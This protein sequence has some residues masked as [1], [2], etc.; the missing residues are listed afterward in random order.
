VGVITIDRR[1]RCNALDVMTARDLHQATLTMARD[2]AVR[3]VVLRGTGG[4]FCS[5]ADQK[6]IIG[7][8]Q[9][10]RERTI[11]ARDPKRILEERSA[12]CYTSSTS[13]YSTL[14]VREKAQRRCS[15]KAESRGKDMCLTDFPLGLPAC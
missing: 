3:C 14:T 15:S 12:R 10:P 2:G 7:H 13:A 6:Y 5:G 11:P 4:V 8:G 9:K 1:E